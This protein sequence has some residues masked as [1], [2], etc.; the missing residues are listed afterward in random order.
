MTTTPIEARSTNGRARTAECRT[1]LASRTINM[2][3]IAK[4]ATATR[5]T[6][7]QVAL[8]CLVSALTGSPR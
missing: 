1:M 8:G 5:P 2:Y 3:E 4:A 6:T 7:R